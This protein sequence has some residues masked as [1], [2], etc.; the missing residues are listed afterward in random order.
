[1]LRGPL[2]NLG[3]GTQ[4]LRSDSAWTSFPE[5]QSELQGLDSGQ[6]CRKVLA[7]GQ[8]GHNAVS[9]SRLPAWKQGRGRTADLPAAPPMPPEGA[10]SHPALLT[11]SKS[12]Q[13]CTRKWGYDLSHLRGPSWMLHF[14]Q[15]RT[16]S[17]SGR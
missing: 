3:A 12:L 7:Q 11:T 17:V 5:T 1:M 6:Y 9:P 14:P 2:I 8:A 4:D 15:P 16:H 13:P 10:S